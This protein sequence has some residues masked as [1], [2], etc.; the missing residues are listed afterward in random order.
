[1]VFDEPFTHLDKEGVEGVVDCLRWW[2]EV[3]EGGNVLVPMQDMVGLEVEEKFDRVIFV[4]RGGGDG[5]GDGEG[6]GE[7][8]F[9]V[10]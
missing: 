5:D 3:E 10:A 8:S 4:E 9:I 2:V 7:G 6:D 1:M